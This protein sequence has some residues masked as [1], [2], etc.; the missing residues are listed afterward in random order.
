MLHIFRSYSILRNKNENYSSEQVWD[1]GV[2]PPEAPSSISRGVIGTHKTPYR[3]KVL[4]IAHNAI[5]LEPF[6]IWQMKIFGLDDSDNYSTAV[7]GVFGP[8]SHT[9][10]TQ[11]AITEEVQVWRI[12]EISEQVNWLHDIITF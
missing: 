1:Y 4:D 11:G 3:S 9:G 6:H 7:Q 10:N 8:W 5:C 12:D 2:L